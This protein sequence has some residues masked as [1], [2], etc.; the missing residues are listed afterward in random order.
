MI[1][2]AVV[3]EVDYLKGDM[4][5]IMIVVEVED[6]AGIVE[7]VIEFEFEVEYEV[8]FELE[9]EFKVVFEIGLEVIL[10]FI[11]IS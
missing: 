1:V 2:K 8:D 4:E 11:R 5:K 9:L 3:I 10:L 7:I 6:G